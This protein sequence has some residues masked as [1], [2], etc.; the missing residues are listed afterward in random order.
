MRAITYKSIPRTRILEKL[1]FPDIERNI[2]VVKLNT[3]VSNAK[4]APIA[5]IGILDC[6]NL[7]A[8]IGSLNDKQHNDY[9]K[10]IAHIISF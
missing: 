9:A 10:H 1:T 8:S 7:I 2:N 3:I 4:A 5:I 6:V